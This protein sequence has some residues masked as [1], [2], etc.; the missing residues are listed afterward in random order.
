LRQLFFSVFFHRRGEIFTFDD[1]SA[2]PETHIL[3]VRSSFGYT[4]AQTISKQ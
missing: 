3:A 2:P 1:E 4:F